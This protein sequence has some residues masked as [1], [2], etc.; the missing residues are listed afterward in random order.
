M[1]HEI[2]Y[3]LLVPQYFITFIYCARVEN[4]DRVVYFIKRWTNGSL[5]TYGTEANYRISFCTVTA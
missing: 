1:S 5:D 3:I 2:N 4:Y